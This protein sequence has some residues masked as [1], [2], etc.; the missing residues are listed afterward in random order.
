MSK[1]ATDSARLSAGSAFG[2]LGVPDARLVIIG[3][4]E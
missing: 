4:I 3:I 2:A 1:A